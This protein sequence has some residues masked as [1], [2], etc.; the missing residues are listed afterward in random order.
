MQ[1]FIINCQEITYWLEKAS[2]YLTS[3]AKNHVGSTPS[4]QC[5]KKDLNKKSLPR[6]KTTTA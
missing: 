6:Q 1:I 2:K 4:T 5:P 3:R